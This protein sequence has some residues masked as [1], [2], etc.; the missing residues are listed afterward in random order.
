MISSFRK[1][2]HLLDKREKKQS[3]K[4]VI[5]LFITALA[6]SLGVVSIM[7]FLAVLGNPE[8]IK[9]N[10][11]LSQLYE[12]ALI[13]NISTVS[14]F[15]IF[16]GSLAFIFV[17]LSSVLRAITYYNLNN[18]LELI[19]HGVSCRLFDTYLKMDYVNFMNQHSAEMSKSINSTIDQLIAKV[20]RPIFNMVAYVLVFVCI[21]G[22]LVLVNPALVLISTLFLVT[23]YSMIF[24]VIKK[25]L[26][27]LGQLLAVTNR[28]RFKIAIE[29][30]GGFKEMKINTTESHYQKIF[31]KNSLYF[32]KANA[33]Y[34]TLSDIPKFIVESLI[35]AGMITLFLYLTLSPTSSQLNPGLGAALPVIGVYAFAAYRIQPAIQAIFIGA[36]SLKFGKQLINE[37]HDLVTTVKEQKLSSTQMQTIYFNGYITLSNVSYSYQKNSDKQIKNVNLKIGKGETIAF[38]GRSGSGKSTLADLIMGLLP[39]VQGNVKIDGTLLDER[40]KMTWFRK[41]GYVPQE[42]FLTDTDIRENIAFGIKKEDIDQSQVEYCSKLADI[43]DHIIRNLED[44]Y[45]TRVGERGIKLSGGQRQRLAIAR[46]LYRNPEVLVLDEATSA[47]DITTERTV[48]ENI[49]SEFREK[50]IIMI[51]HRISTL[52]NCDK[53][54]LLSEGEIVDVDSYDALAE[55]NVEFEKFLSLGRQRSER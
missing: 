30:F 13:F 48:L 25:M 28:K 50:T 21:V 40:S 49:Q 52:K 20:L 11:M 15:M 17:L 18:N 14:G 45:S 24:L 9:S 6:D 44:G 29:V 36:S 31:N 42:L 47:M 27:K 26:S 38:F 2:L 54:C 37:I 3:A 8:L 1:I 16:L 10:F 7:P 55:K 32:S 19:R 43:H 22:I 5:L 33:N 34:Q 53:V 12:F 4:L 35:F 46:A 39:A 51:T 41:I 23:V